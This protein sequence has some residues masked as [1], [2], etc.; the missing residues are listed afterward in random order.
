MAATATTVHRTGSRAHLLSTIYQTSVTSMSAS[1]NDLVSKEMLCILQFIVY[2][3]IDLNIKDALLI[4]DY[5]CLSYCMYVHVCM[6]MY[7]C[8]VPTYMT[9]HCSVTVYMCV[10]LCM[11]VMYLRI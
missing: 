5:Q 9:M 11:Y 4:S 7:V 6:C 3:R 8:N 1:V 2:V 10:C